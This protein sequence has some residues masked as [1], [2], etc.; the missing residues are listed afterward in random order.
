MCIRDS[1]YTPTNPD[2]S[3]ITLG[4]GSTALLN[5]EGGNIDLRV[6]YIGYA[7][8]SITYK[9]AGVSAYNA[10]QVHVEKRMSH[11]VQVGASYTCLLYTSR[12]V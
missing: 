2:G 9:A 4:D 10:L 11:G 1:G 8:E 6:P 5:Y 7:A 12:C 3:F